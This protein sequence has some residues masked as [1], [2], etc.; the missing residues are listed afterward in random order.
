MF[1]ESYLLSNPP[2]PRI[3]CR[4]SFASASVTSIFRPPTAADRVFDLPCFWRLTG[5]GARGLEG[6]ARNG[7]NESL[8]SSDLDGDKESALNPSESISTFPCVLARRR[9]VFKGVW[10]AQSSENMIVQRQ[11]KSVT[12]S[13]CGYLSQARARVETIA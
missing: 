2:L 1:I 5:D 4:A 3:P 10:G 9:G 8:G 6:G 13:W 11:A 12:W 7:F